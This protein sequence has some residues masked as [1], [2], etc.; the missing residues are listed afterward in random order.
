MKNNI[1]MTKH[2]P[3]F[4]NLNIYS[5]HLHSESCV[6]MQPQM[7]ER[8]NDSGARAI[9]GRCMSVKYNFT[10]IMQFDESILQPL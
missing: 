5:P 10:N 6:I 9:V 2:N 8:R 7:N 1:Q 4:D 3:N